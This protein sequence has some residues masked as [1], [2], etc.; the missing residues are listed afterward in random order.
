MLLLPSDL[1]RTLGSAENVFLE[2]LLTTF[3]LRPR[4]GFRGGARLSVGFDSRTPAVWNRS[5]RDFVREAVRSQLGGHFSAVLKAYQDRISAVLSNGKE[6]VFPTGESPLLWRWASAG[7][8]PIVTFQDELYYCLFYREI[9]PIG[10]N[11]A[12][13]ACDNRDELLYPLQALERELAEELVVLNPKRRVRYTLQPEEEQRNLDR[14]EFA[15][16]RRLWSKQFKNL[17]LQ[18]FVPEPLA[19]K[20]EYG[21]D[22]VLVNTD[23]GKSRLKDCFININA[24]D[25]GIE[26]DRIATIAL[27]DD[28]VLCDG[29]CRPDRVLNRPVGLFKVKKLQQ[30]VSSGRKEFIPD[31]FFYSGKR[32]HGTSWRNFLHGAFSID[33]GQWRTPKEIKAFEDAARKNDLCPVTRSIVERHSGYSSAPA[34]LK[35]DLR[36]A[37]R[38]DAFLSYAK[39]DQEIAKR[40]F[41]YLSAKLKLS[42]FFSPV[43]LPAKREMWSIPIYKALRRS[44]ALVVVASKKRYLE[45]DWVNFEIVAFHQRHRTKAPIIPLI[46]GFSDRSLSEP[47][48]CYQAL[49]WSDG[50]SFREAL[51]QLGGRLQAAKTQADG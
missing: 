30:A 51:E 39:P 25:L 27:P 47:V 29:E 2:V 19:C 21:P 23:Y 28:V 48:S 42:V 18:D 43:E 35:R 26:L 15:N 10:W 16:F 49:S 22:E 9:F 20:W 41:K 13:G 8:L 24:A 46:T 45:R 7:T 4:R 11:I 3:T 32:W 12:N 50:T 33:V 38:Y 44:S 5:G 17:D 34:S 1:V 40:V 36:K 14:P 31:L 6:V 37:G